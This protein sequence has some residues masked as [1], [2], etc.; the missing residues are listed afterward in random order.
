MQTVAHIPKD[1]EGT[2][3]LVHYKRTIH[4]SRAALILPKVIS[5]QG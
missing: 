2:Y 4:A 3:I 1:R 5:S